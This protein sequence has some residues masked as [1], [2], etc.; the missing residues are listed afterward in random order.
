[1]SEFE[2]ESQGPPAELPP[3]RPAIRAID[4]SAADMGTLVDMGLVEEQPE[5]PPTLAPD[6]D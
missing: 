1:M 6:A 3:E 5:P 4:E 2:V